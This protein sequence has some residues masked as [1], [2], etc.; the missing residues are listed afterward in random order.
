MSHC[1][2]PIPTRT[3]ALK[4]LTC[5]QCGERIERRQLKLWVCPSCHTSFGIA[6]SYQRCADLVM[7]ASV[8]FLAAMTHKST[9]DGT[10]LLGVIL[11]GVPCWFLFLVLVPPW[12]KQG[13]N[14]V[15]VTVLSS[16]LGAAMTIFLAGLGWSAVIMLLGGSKQDLQEH[17]AMLSLPLVYVSPNF[18][19]TTDSSFTDM[20]GVVLGNSFFFG[21]LMFACYQTVR[22]FFHRNRPTQLSLS[23]PNHTDDD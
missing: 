1:D 9:S 17:W 22:W 8:A 12:L 16:Y 2:P 5:P 15:R 7:F 20:C 19:I 23:G 3:V 18:L 14:Q 10:W 6:H 4:P 13:S 11:P 21:L